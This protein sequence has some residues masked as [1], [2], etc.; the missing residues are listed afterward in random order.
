[1]RN[2]WLIDPEDE[3][4]G[5]N[6]GS[7]ALSQLIGSAPDTLFH[8]TSA[9][10]LRGILES[11]EIWATDTRFLNDRTEV[12]HGIDICRRELSSERLK[13]PFARI[14]KVAGSR[15]SDSSFLFFAACLC[16]E[17]DLIP[18]WRGYAASGA[19]YSIGFSTSSL[20]DVKGIVPI[21]AIYDDEEKVLLTRAM[22]D[23]FEEAWEKSSDRFHGKKKDV[24]IACAT[25]LRTGLTIL[26]L[27]YKPSAFSYER[28]W[29]FVD[30]MGR[31]DLPS[32]AQLRFRESAGIISPYVGLPLTSPGAPA[33][34]LPIQSVTCGP[35][36]ANDAAVSAIELLLASKGIT[37]VVRKSVAPLRF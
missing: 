11:K 31:Q 20:V 6:V 2:D 3:F 30:I 8:Y 36:L 37:S 28:E 24:A 18:Q 5:M 7:A 27:G 15:L 35:T 23:K 13:H 21:R 22:I 34:A 32:A 25:A 16:E 4:P 9:T 17:D 1:M 14:C 10:G 29:R 12:A 26:S 33:S 19:G